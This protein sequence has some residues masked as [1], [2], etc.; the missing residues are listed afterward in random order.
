MVSE[1]EYDKNQM[2]FRAQMQT[3]GPSPTTA[4]T[5]PGTMGQATGT[6]PGTAG[7]TA[8]G[9]LYTSL[10]HPEIDE[11]ITNL[12]N[13]YGMDTPMGKKILLGGAGATGGIAQQAGQMA[14]VQLSRRAIALLSGSTI[15]GSAI[16][17]F[18]SVP[19]S[20]IGK[21]VN[22]WASEY[23][24]DLGNL[25]LNAF[26][27]MYTIPVEDM[28][29]GQWTYLFND[30]TELRKRMAE[31][32]VPV[33]LIDNRVI[34][35][36]QLRMANEEIIGAAGPLESL[37][38]TGQIQTG[39]LPFSAAQRITKEQQT[40]KEK[41]MAEQQKQ[42]EYLIK[43]VNIE[44]RT[45]SEIDIINRRALAG[46]QNYPTTQAGQIIA[47]L[48]EE[49]QPELRKPEQMPM[50]GATKPTTPRDLPQ[51]APKPKI[52][53]PTS[54]TQAAAQPPAA[55]WTPITGA[56]THQQEFEGA[57]AGYRWNP[58]KQIWEKV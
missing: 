7:T 52:T 34:Q 25:R 54:A 19:N 47:P 32:G 53:A 33:D 44:G 56:P 23:N 22:A 42:E 27:Q 6:S 18:M 50:A 16:A 49:T 35:L 28:K 43:P 30:E 51:A 48:K 14:Q 37:R 8:S 31:A 3:A 2:A 21:Q 57:R 41:L 13:T 10:G 12:A 11:A 40:A 36:S 9:G 39:E 4:G 17:A 55:L 24:I 1:A 38:E 26:E 29:T 58:F 5:S 45:Q 15:M 46:S 20:I